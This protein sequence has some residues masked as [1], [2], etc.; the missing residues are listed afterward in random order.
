MARVHRPS[1]EEKFN[2]DK[3]FNS[4]SRVHKCYRR[5]TDRRQTD[6]L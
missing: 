5:Q 3:S 2:I 4:L 6:L 1:G